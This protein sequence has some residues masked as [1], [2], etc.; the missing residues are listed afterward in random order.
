MKSSAAKAVVFADLDG[1]LINEEYSYE[2][3]QQ[4]LE[5]L[6]ALNTSIVLCSSKTS[7]EI[8]YYQKELGIADPFSSE[9]GA[10]VFIPKGYFGVSY[11]CSRQTEK[12]NVVELGTPYSKLRDALAQVRMETGA[13]IVGFGDLTTAEVAEDTGLSFELAKLAQLREYDE[14]FRIIEGDQKRVVALLE[15]KGLSVTQGD[16]YFHL[17]GSHNKGKAVALLTKLYLKTFR[18]IRTFGVGN[19]PNDLEMLKVVDMPFFVQKTMNLS[20]VW[21]TILADITHLASGMP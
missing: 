10:A 1:T 19:G 7:A 20:E 6:L 3:T 21:Q 4:T 5:R 8:E 2:G 17:T 11:D 15:R 9:N 14:P 18:K 13:E 12:Y 16:R